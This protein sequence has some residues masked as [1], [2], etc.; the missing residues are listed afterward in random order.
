MM[1]QWWWSGQ[2]WKN[3]G[4]GIDGDVRMVAKL[5]GEANCQFSRTDPHTDRHQGWQ[6]LT[7]KTLRYRLLWLPGEHTRPQNRPTLRLANSP[8][9]RGWTENVLNRIQKVKPLD[10]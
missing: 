6:G 1:G 5:R 7:L 3:H 8:V 10:P 2:S 9:V 4:I